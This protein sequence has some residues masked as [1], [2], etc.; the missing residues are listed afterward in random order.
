MSP[1]GLTVQPR[2]SPGPTADRTQPVNLSVSEIRE[3][4]ATTK[5]T[6]SQ[7]GT[8]YTTGVHR[9]PSTEEECLPV[10]G[11]H[12]VTP[13]LSISHLFL[14][15]LESYVTR[16]KL[17]NIF[18]RSCTLL[19]EESHSRLISFVCCASQQTYLTT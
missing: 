17:Y 11:F 4:L 6:P 18:A 16:S 8:L 15:L 14:S 19:C 7:A 1:V 9:V 10:S 5:V 3:T 12:C 13:T 2:R